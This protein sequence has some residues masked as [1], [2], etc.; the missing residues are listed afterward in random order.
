[1]NKIK[2]TYACLFSSMWG[3]MKSLISI[4]H[5]DNVMSI[6]N[7]IDYDYDS[8]CNT[9]YQMADDFMNGDHEDSYL[10]FDEYVYSKILKL[11]REEIDALEDR[12]ANIIAMPYMPGDSLFEIC[13]SDD[14]I[15]K[16]EERKHGINSVVVRKDHDTK[17]LQF[18]IVDDYARD[19]IVPANTTDYVCTSYDIALKRFVDRYG[20]MPD[21]V[22][23]SHKLWPCLSAGP[24]GVVS[25]TDAAGCQFFSFK[26][27]DNKPVKICFNNDLV[28]EVKWR[29]A[30]VSI[31]PVNK[32]SIDFFC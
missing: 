3:E 8:F 29:L 17:E 2:D 28:F 21:N 23:K 22:E 31:L 30:Y 10:S 4:L 24:D 11:S 26:L 7:G 20:T 15:P 27:G 1:M 19:Y 18:D 6:M 13:D 32:G 12:I 25:L 5:E 14:G 9:M 16:I